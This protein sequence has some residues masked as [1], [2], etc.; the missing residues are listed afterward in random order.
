MDPITLAITTTLSAGALTSLSKVAEQSV[1]DAYEALK[2][3][4]KKKYGEEKDLINAVENLERKPESEARK[5]LL[6]EEILAK[7]IHYDKEL[8]ELAQSLIELISDREQL[9]ANR[10]D[11]DGDG[12]IIAENSTIKTTTLKDHSTLVE[13]ANE[14]YTGT[15]YKEGKK[16]GSSNTN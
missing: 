9:V 13:S 2:N 3:M 7:K 6:E 16:K 15:V 1:L 5:L 8:I 10:I 14:V 4:M 11:I 12:N